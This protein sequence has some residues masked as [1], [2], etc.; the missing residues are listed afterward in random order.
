MDTRV[1]V[2]AETNITFYSIR[3]YMKCEMTFEIGGWKVL[4]SACHLD[5]SH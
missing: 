4:G 1:D 5:L 3:I 2:V